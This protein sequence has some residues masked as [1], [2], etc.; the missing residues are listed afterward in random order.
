MAGVPE[1]PWNADAVRT[2]GSEVA[3]KVEGVPG[4]GT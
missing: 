2:D 3:G 4:Q 1:Q